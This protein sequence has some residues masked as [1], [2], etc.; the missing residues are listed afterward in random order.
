MGN[1]KYFTNGNIKENPTLVYQ[2]TLSSELKDI[3]PFEWNGKMNQ[4]DYAGNVITND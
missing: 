4:G 3:T 1:L 2:S